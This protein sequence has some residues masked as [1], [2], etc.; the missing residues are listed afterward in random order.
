MK[1]SA[2]HET[3]HDTDVDGHG[4]NAPTDPSK[5]VKRGFATIRRDEC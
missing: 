5:L 1:A 4:R 2:S 3:T